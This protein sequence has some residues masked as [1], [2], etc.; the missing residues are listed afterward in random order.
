[1]EQVYKM[2]VKTSKPGSKVKPIDKVLMFL[3]QEQNALALQK[4][5]EKQRAIDEINRD[6]NQ[7]EELNY[8]ELKKN[9]TG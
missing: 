6:Q 4:E 8:G 5:K 2:A 7:L 9:L 3:K 1:M